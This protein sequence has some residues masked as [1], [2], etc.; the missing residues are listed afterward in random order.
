MSEARDKIVKDFIDN[1]DRPHRDEW[2]IFLEG[3]NAA[4][5][6]SGLTHMPCDMTMIFD[7]FMEFIKKRI[8][9]EGWTDSEMGQAQIDQ[10]MA[11]FKQQHGLPGDE[12]EGLGKREQPE[13]A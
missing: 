5:E 8:V 6:M 7:S 3:F 9:A 2:R 1:L 11:D 13:E 4:F 12:D 10:M